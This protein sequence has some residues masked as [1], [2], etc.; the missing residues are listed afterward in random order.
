MLASNKMRKQRL[1]RTLS[2][3]HVKNL[4]ALCVN[5]GTNKTKESESVSPL[6]GCYGWI[7]RMECSYILIPV[8]PCLSDLSD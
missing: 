2:Y 4:S 1:Q 8:N 5:L 6:A 3:L 7:Q